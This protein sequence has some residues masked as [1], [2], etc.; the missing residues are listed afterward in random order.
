MRLSDFWS[1]MREWFGEGYAESI[2]HDLVLADLGERTVVQALD[3]GV[4]AKD[5]WR[6]VCE[7]FEI[8]ANRR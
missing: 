6:A 2:A 3:A 7:A 1:R 4:P 8:P 5:V